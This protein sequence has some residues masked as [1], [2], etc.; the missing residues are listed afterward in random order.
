LDQYAGCDKI[1]YG[2]FKAHRAW[3]KIA[4]EMLGNAASL[5]AAGDETGGMM[6]SYAAYV[7][8]LI[9]MDL[10]AVRDKGTE[11]F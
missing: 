4:G 2:I 7:S 6:R 3:D 10:L 11:F 1:H 9:F 8:R 5:R